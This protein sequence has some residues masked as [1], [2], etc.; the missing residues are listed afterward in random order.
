MMTLEQTHARSRL[1]AWLA[2]AMDGGTG[3]G[4]VF[5]PA[6]TLQLMMVPVP[7]EEALFYLRFVGV[8]VGMV[9]FSYLG[10]VGRGTAWDL[11]AVLR[12]TVPFRLAAGLFC[13]VGVGVGELAPMWLSVAGADWMLVGLQIGLLRGK[14][15]A[16]A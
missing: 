14:W 15:E 12:F 11:R 13:A 5:A 8:F 3:L 7:G 1:L 9:G 2:G 16:P 6:L 4:K 10:A